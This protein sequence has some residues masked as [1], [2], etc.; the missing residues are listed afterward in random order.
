[1]IETTLPKVPGDIGDPDGV[2]NTDFDAGRMTRYAYPIRTMYKLSTPVT[3][4]ELYA[5]FAIKSPQGFC[6]ATRLFVEAFPPE[7][8][9]QIL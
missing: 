9:E 5:R 2:G 3:R 8:L 1:M 4:D 7:D 6:Y